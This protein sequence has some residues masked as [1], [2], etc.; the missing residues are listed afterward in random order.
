MISANIKNSTRK[1]V[2]RRDGY[3]CAI[4][5]STKYIQIHHCI[6]RSEGGG[7][8][9]HN[10]ITLCSNCHALAHGTKLDDTPFEREDMELAICE[11][12]QD[13]YLDEWN[14]WRRE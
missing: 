12:L 6:P 9:I 7:N 10:L 11:Y 2:Y 5:D 14:P 1:A 4:C 8:F 13:M 3:R